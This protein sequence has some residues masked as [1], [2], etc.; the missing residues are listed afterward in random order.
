[1]AS[2]YILQLLLAEIHEMYNSTVGADNPVDEDTLPARLTGMNADHAADQKKLGRGVGG[3]DGWKQQSD[4]KLRGEKEL[5]SWHQDNLLPFPVQA[6]AK[7][8]D[9]AGGM[10]AFNA[11]PVAEQV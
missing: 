11:L 4:R 8:I 10:D 6:S 3:A 7:K 5:K 9:A 2:I 1:M